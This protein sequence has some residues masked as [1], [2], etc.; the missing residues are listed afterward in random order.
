MSYETKTIIILIAALLRKANNS[1]EVY[2]ELKRIAN[3]ESID[4]PDFED[5]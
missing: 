1:E 5:K 3:S 2:R 4:L